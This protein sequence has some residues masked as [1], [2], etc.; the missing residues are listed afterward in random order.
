MQRLVSAELSGRSLYVS[1]GGFEAYAELRAPDWPRQ[2]TRLR[3]PGSIEVWLG[4][5]Y[6]CL[7]RARQQRPEEVTKDPQ[8]SGREDDQRECKVLAFKGPVRAA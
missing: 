2:W 5:A 7:S 6:F 3:E 1:L 4:R 8:P